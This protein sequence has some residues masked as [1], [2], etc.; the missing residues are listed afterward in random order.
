MSN[1]ED[2]SGMEAPSGE[3]P[4][5]GDTE[6]GINPAL[7]A[8]LDHAESESAV[9][10]ARLLICLESA[11]LW[12]DLLPTYSARQ[13]RRGNWWALAS[14]ALAAFTGLAIWPLVT[15]QLPDEILG[16][17]GQIVAGA[18]VSLVAFASAICT[19][20]PRILRYTEMAERAQ[21][22]T[23]VYGSALGLLL[24]LVAGKQPVDQDKAHHAVEV[25]REAKVRKDRLDRL[26]K[27]PD[28]TLHTKEFAARLATGARIAAEARKHTV[29][30]LSHDPG[31][32]KSTDAARLEAASDLAGQGRSVQQRPATSPTELA[33]RT[34]SSA[35]VSEAKPGASPGSSPH[36]SA[37]ASQPS[38]ALR[39]EYVSI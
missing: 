35:V 34:D 3:P 27:R 25:F 37:D 6:G 5:T 2:A 13:K 38:T 21:E 33:Q 20:V 29:Q 17:P 11:A 23:S 30:R 28:S 15:D 16:M 18:F 22:L 7:R 1:V 8:I 12:V 39:D 14:G 32:Q 19:L 4:E 24:D 31:P 36:R 26:P 10:G 9:T